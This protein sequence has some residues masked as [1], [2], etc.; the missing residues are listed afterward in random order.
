M[1]YHI[2]CFH[3]HLM[4]SWKFFKGSVTL[5]KSHKY[6]GSKIVPVRIPDGMLA[7]IMGQ[8]HSPKQR[9]TDQPYNVGSWIRKAVQEKLD[10]LA[11]RG[12]RK[13]SLRIAKGSM[14]SCELPNCHV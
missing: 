5:E 12:K 11:R 8:I 14:A 6:S 10:H 3:D 2:P 9:I 7:Q 4:G 13:P 1:P